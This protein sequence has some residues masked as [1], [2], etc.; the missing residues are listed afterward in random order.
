MNSHPTNTN[1]IQI[2][3]NNLRRVPFYIAVGD[4]TVSSWLFAPTTPKSKLGVLVFPPLAHDYV[5]S[6]PTLNDLSTK[7]AVNG[8]PTLRFDYLGTGDSSGDMNDG[9]FLSNL[10][11][12]VNAVIDYFLDATS[13]DRL[14]LIGLKPGSMFAALSANHP[15]VDS[16]VLWAPYTRGKEYVRELKVLQA[17]QTMGRT[18]NSSTE[19][20]RCHGFVYPGEFIH[21]MKEIDLRKLEVP[22]SLNALIVAR[23]DYPENTSIVSKWNSQGADVEY[24]RLPGIAGLELPVYDAILPTEAIKYIA[25]W[26]TKRSEEYP[27]P[28]TSSIKGFPNS[29]PQKAKNF[30]KDESD[31]IESPF[32]FGPNN[33]LFG[34]LSEPKNG[35]SN[36]KPYVLFL[37]SGGAR[38]IGPGRLYISIARSFAQM[39]YGC[40]RLDITG[41]GDSAVIE[42]HAANDPYT[43]TIID[44]VTYAV[45]ALKQQRKA[46]QFI[47]VGHC[48]GAWASFSSVVQIENEPIVEAILL[49][50]VVYYWEEGMTMDVNPSQEFS[51]FAYYL[52][53][54]RQWQKWAKFFTGKVS[55]KEIFGT[56]FSVLKTRLPWLNPKPKVKEPTSQ[57]TNDQS[58]S[59]GDLAGDILKTVE[60]KRRMTFVFTAREPGEMQLNTY[61]KRPVRK[62]N[63]LGLITRYRGTMVDHNLVTKEAQDYVLGTL[64]DHMS[65]RHP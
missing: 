16:I 14:C 8:I 34:V 32:V 61:A 22:S 58:E 49:N 39:G 63:R 37:N 17:T 50:P 55:Y 64:L 10:D 41:V 24:T 30:P 18:E 56:V 29:L 4:R 59:S 40:L 44:D 48:A 27:Q 43:S 19:E 7:L 6:Y 11:A 57:D 42:G 21:S 26:V 9:D 62:G 33:S 52:D 25:N 15:N 54:A 46:D 3:E 2:D 65:E 20:V 31:I 53:M 1:L 35:A 5:Q 28:S 36:R 38:H 60:N 45:Q 13:C 12:T 51:Q 47:V 23:D